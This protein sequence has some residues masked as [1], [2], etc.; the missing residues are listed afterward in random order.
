MGEACAVLWRRKKALTFFLRFLFSFFSRN[1]AKTCFVKDAKNLARSGGQ[2]PRDVVVQIG[3]E[4]FIHAQSYR[5]GSVAEFVAGD[6]ADCNHV[7]IGGGNEKLI[8]GIKILDTQ[9]VFFH[10]GTGFANDFKKD[11]ARYTFQAARTQRWSENGVALDDIEIRGGTFGDFAAFVEHDDFVES[12]FLRFGDRPDIVEPG[13]C[14][15]ASE[16]GGGMAAMFANSETNW[17]V[18]FG[19]RRGVND[20]IDCGLRFIAAPKTDLIVEE[21]DARA[22]IGN[23]IGA[24]H[25]L[26]L[27]ANARSGVRHGQMNDDSVFFQAAPVA[28]KGE[29]FA[30]HDAQR[31]EESPA[32]D[33]A[34]LPGREP[35][36]FDGQK[37]VVVKDV[38]M[39][40]G[41]CLAGSGIKNIV[42]EREG[43]GG[44]RGRKQE[45]R[46]FWKGLRPKLG[47]AGLRNIAMTSKASNQPRIWNPVL[48]VARPLTTI[49]LAE[50]S[51]QEG[52]DGGGG[53]R[54]LFGTGSSKARSQN[55]LRWSRKT[56]QKSTADA[57]LSRCI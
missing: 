20:Q 14:L 16:R 32:V 52:V 19:K 18:V 8:G 15:Y 12:V 25:F 22:A 3:S 13:N 33:D 50:K 49:G 6:F 42:A 45:R 34:G 7:A 28:F 38:A 43:G 48:E 10:D 54:V 9:S 4:G 29:G 47:M 36:F 40:Q 5:S 55:W 27:D 39:N 37:L 53:S 30:T 21:V 23:F 1:F 17:L 44:E 56:E 2:A 51:L 11:A 41:A 57:Q 46:S 35:Y 24:D 31:G 26:K